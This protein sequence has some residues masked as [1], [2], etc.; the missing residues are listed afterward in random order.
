[1]LTT[2]TPTLKKYKDAF[3]SFLKKKKYPTVKYQGGFYCDIDDLRAFMYP[4]IS[5][6]D[7]RAARLPDEYRNRYEKRVNSDP[8]R[9][10]AA[11]RTIL[12]KNKV[13]AEIMSS[14]RSSLDII[15]IKN[16]AKYL[17]YNPDG[18]G[19]SEVTSNPTRLIKLGFQEKGKK[20]SGEGKFATYQM[21][22]E[23][24][25][26]LVVS[27]M[28]DLYWPT[29]WDKLEAFNKSLVVLIERRKSIRRARGILTYQWRRFDEC[30]QDRRREENGD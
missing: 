26:Q 21:S 11:E 6:Q 14:C 10:S 1:M 23:D 25:Q 15:K 29:L 17:R 27:Q 5:E 20:L 12:G 7:A 22:E 19:Y 16:K 13:I 8:I 24:L 30:I 2:K 9:R 4:I 18:G 28:S 3:L